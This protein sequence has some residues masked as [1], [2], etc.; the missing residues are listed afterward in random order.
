MWS[1][2]SAKEK[3]DLM[4][5]YK[6]AG[7]SYS[8]M[9]KDYDNSYKKFEDGGEL[10][11]KTYNTSE[12]VNQQPVIDPYLKAQQVNRGNKIQE[13]EKR[14]LAL[15]YYNKRKNQRMLGQ[16]GTAEELDKINKDVS[17]Y[18]A[19]NSINYKHKSISEKAKDIGEIA[20]DVASFSPGRLG[21]AVYM[22]SLPFTTSDVS[23]SLDDK[24]YTQ[25]GLD[26]LGY[27]PAFSHYSLGAKGEKVLEKNTKLAKQYKK[28][29]N[30]VNTT[31]ISNDINST[32]IFNKE[33]LS[34]TSSS[35]IY[36]MSKGPAFLN[37]K[38]SLMEKG[39]VDLEG[40]TFYP[41]TYRDLYKK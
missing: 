10:P 30:T 18:S 4:K 13:E 32:D 34:K 41:N 31:N 7:F 15:E 38:P 23:K 1:K 3:G 19:N 33:W 25:A 26:A 16:K 22:A 6:K 12:T 9:I 36:P 24:N 17:S 40:N 11:I 20:L 37:T 27:L 28:V 29:N 35:K 39:V 8:D 14:V 21:K 5:G 2:L